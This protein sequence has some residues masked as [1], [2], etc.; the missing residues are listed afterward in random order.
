LIVVA[1]TFRRWRPDTRLVYFG[2][3]RSLLA[4]GIY[5][6]RSALNA[7]DAAKLAPEIADRLGEATLNSPPGVVVIENLVEFVQSQADAAMQEMI[8]AVTANGHLVVSDGEA[9]P[10]AGLATLLQL[11][12]ASRTGLVLQPEQSDGNLLKTQFPRVRKSD[13]PPGRGFYVFRG[14]TPVVVQVAHPGSSPH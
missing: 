13:F 7:A 6:D 14:E 8:K 11:A 5:W 12:R 9:G 1:T 3:K 4:T 2:S 10:L